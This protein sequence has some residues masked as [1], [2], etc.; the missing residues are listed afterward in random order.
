MKKEDGFTG[1]NWHLPL[2]LK[3]ELH[4]SGLPGASHK[5]GGRGV[6]YPRQGVMCSK[7]ETA[8]PGRVPQ[9][10]RHESSVRYLESQL[11]SEIHLG[12]SFPFISGKEH[13]GHELR[14][15]GETWSQLPEDA[16]P[17]P[18]GLNPKSKTSPLKPS[19]ASGAW[20]GASL[21]HSVFFH[22]PSGFTSE[23]ER[24]MRVA[25]RPF[26][27]FGPFEEWAALGKLAMAQDNNNK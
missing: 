22:L 21:L 15:V 10:D 26:A 20:H 5:L 24:L 11:F 18:S 19:H 27:S 23:A 2:T 3:E 7:A 6:K 16:P 8:L 14:I 4:Q 13:S 9:E 12:S 25:S 17:S 1:A